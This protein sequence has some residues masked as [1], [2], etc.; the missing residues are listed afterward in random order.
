ML[1]Q[2]LETLFEFLFF[3]LQNRTHFSDYTV[4]SEF[5]Y[6]DK[7]GKPQ[8]SQYVLIISNWHFIREHQDKKESPPC[9][10]ENCN[11]S[12]KL[13]CSVFKSA[14]SDLSVSGSGYLDP[15][16][17]DGF[18]FDKNGAIIPYSAFLSLLDDKYF[19]NDFLPEVKTE[20]EKLCGPVNLEKE[21]PPR[22]D[23][24]S[25]TESAAPGK[26]AQL[27]VSEEEDDD[28]ADDDDEDENKKKKKGKTTKKRGGKGEDNADRDDEVRGSSASGSK[29]SRAAK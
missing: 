23:T 28:V 19:V 5:N 17:D 2:A 20:Y 1:A 27:V 4:L 9:K 18:S 24:D 26:R 15:L 10:P 25:E 16:P 11:I 7:K 8:Q 6:T 21:L 14:P 29:R 12:I 13:S 3:S 22:D